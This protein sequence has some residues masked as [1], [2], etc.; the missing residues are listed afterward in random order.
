MTIY[1]V[2]VL[3]MNYIEQMYAFK[4]LEEAQSKAFLLARKWVNSDTFNEYLEKYK[5]AKID[6]ETYNDYYLTVEDDS[7][8]DIQS[9]IL[10]QGPA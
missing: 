4:T 3:Y 1:I 10:E 9:V 6:L 5:P 7:Y 2:Y 8:V